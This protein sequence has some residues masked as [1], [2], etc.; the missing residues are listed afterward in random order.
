MNTKLILAQEVFSNRD[1]ALSAS[2]GYMVH[3][4]L[5]AG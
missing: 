4:N 5:A 3:G 1:P 2:T